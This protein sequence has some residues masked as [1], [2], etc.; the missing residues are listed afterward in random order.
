VY[1]AGCKVCVGNL[2]PPDK[3]LNWAFSEDTGWAMGNQARTSEL[4][5][6]GLHSGILGTLIH[7]EINQSHEFN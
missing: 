7:N 5:F 6:T 3:L 2:P 4:S 1:A